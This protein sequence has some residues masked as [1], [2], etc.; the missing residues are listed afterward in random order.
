MLLLSA[1]SGA[2]LSSHALFLD[3]KGAKI[4]AVYRFPACS[5][6][7]QRDKQGRRDEAIMPRSSKLALVRSALGSLELIA[8]CFL[9]APGVVFSSS[10][11]LLHRH[12]SFPS[13]KR[14]K[15]RARRGLPSLV[16]L[17]GRQQAVPAG[18]AAHAIAATAAHAWPI[19][20]PPVAPCSFFRYSTALGIK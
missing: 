8:G 13:A 3:K 2:G 4:K 7:G 20:L 14:Y 17:A 11:D 18:G 15:A 19:C 16:A 9:R 6:R 1:G 5:G 10:T 12:Y